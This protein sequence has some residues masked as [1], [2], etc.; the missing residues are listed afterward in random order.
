MIRPIKSAAKRLLRHR[1]G[2]YYQLL[3]RRTSTADIRAAL[4]ALEIGPGS[5]VLVHSALSSLGYFRPGAEGL[6]RLLVE[7][8]G[9]DGTILMPAFPFTG[10]MEDYVAG[11]PGFDVRSTPSRSGHLTEAFRRHPGV[12]RSL[13]PTHSFC[14]LGG[15]ADEL[16]RGHHEARTPCGPDSPLGRFAAGDGVVLRLGTGALTLYHHIQELV[17]FPNLFIDGDA[18]LRCR[19]AFGEEFRV[20][21]RVYRRRIPQILHLGVDT[22]TGSWSVHPSDFPLLYRGDRE[23]HYRRDPRRQVLLRRLLAIRG[24]FEARGLLKSHVLHSTPLESFRAKNYRDYA[25]REI[26]SLLREHS[27]SYDLRK[28]EQL[29]AAGA[30]PR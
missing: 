18:V 15:Q 2:Y 24:D 27:S 21:T 12:L 5:T 13:H 28:L 1:R 17:D 8:T 16:T 22:P 9:P 6:I 10:S 3:F 29:L 11:D 19:N 25:V 30:Y 26:R 20:R 4:D 14:A 7:A 23:E